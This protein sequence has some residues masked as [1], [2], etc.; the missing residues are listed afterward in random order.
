[1]NDRY[2]LIAIDNLFE[3]IAVKDMFDQYQFANDLAKTGLEA[4]N[5]V[6]QR[7]IN[8]KEMY[9]LIML[10]FRMPDTLY[11][12]ILRPRCSH[13]SFLT[14]RKSQIEQ[15]TVTLTIT[16]LSR[17]FPLSIRKTCGWQTTK[18][19]HLTHLSLNSRV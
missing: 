11:F 19:T 17:F 15:R 4:V 14:L 1:M 7:F 13:L 2:V 3:L 9:R 10:D 18:E 5:M 12:F 8:G 16:L 6:R